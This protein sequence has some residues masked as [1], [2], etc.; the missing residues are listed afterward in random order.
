[1]YFRAWQSMFVSADGS[2]WRPI[3]LRVK[4]MDLYGWGCVDFMLRAT[5]GTRECIE[6]GVCRLMPS[7]K[8]ILSACARYFLLHGS[9]YQLVPACTLFGTANGITELRNGTSAAEIDFRFRQSDAGALD[10]VSFTRAKGVSRMAGI[11]ASSVGLAAAN[12]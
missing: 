4:S 6:R 11:I 10:A 5:I 3:P 12:S 7:K 8:D 9:C 2:D 1:M